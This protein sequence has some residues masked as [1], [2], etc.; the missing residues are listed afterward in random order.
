MAIYLEINFIQQKLPPEPIGGKDGRNSTTLTIE[1]KKYYL[2][3]TSQRELEQ[4]KLSLKM[5]YEK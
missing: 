5:D 3:G 1:G 4:K 2:Y